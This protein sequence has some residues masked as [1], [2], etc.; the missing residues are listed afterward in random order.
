MIVSRKATDLECISEETFRKYLSELK[1]KYAK[2]TEIRSW[3]S[4]GKIRNKKLDGD[5]YLEISKSNEN[6]SD[7][8]RYMEIA[9]KEYDV[10]FIFKEE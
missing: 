8:E 6:F 5:Y 2:G 9:S 1:S 7:I 3:G 10:T 4:D